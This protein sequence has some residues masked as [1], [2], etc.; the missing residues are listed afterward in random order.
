[1]SG[2]SKILITGAAGF[3]G[4]HSCRY[5]A[6][7]GYE[8]TAVTRSKDIAIDNVMVEQCDLHN[9]ELVLNLIKKV[10]PQYLLHLA[11]QNHVG[12]SWS[13]PTGTLETN[14][15]STVYIL[16]AI[17]KECPE[18]KS[19]IVGSALQIDPSN[20]SAITHPYSLS[21]TFQ[22]L[23]ARAW[24]ELYGLS[25]VIAQPTNLIGPGNSNGVCSMFAKKIAEMES[26]KAEHILNVNNLY[27]QRDFIDVRDAVRAYEILLKNGV[28]KE[29]YPISSGKSRSLGEVVNVFKTMTPINFKVKISERS[30]REDKVKISSERINQLGW[31]P[32]IS[33]K[34]S[35][36]D[37]LKYYRR[38]PY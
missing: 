28:S 5:F 23:A 13:D 7:A 26:Q 10:K 16:D 12:Q 17:H 38:N 30:I 27:A 19:V 37:N 32:I 35:L 18:S 4:L 20:I 34:K 2:K 22:V 36:E 31:K 8:V 21:K 33:F 6:S 11:G 15:L 9:K 24:A 3:T 25:I 14:L 29:I 1:M